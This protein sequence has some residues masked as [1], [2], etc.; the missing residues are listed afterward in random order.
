M[1]A[2]SIASSSFIFSP[3]PDAS[4]V[5]LRLPNCSFCKIL[6]S[7]RSVISISALK[8]IPVELE[9]LPSSA[10]SPSEESRLATASISSAFPLTFAVRVNFSGS[11]T[12]KLS[13]ST[14]LLMSPLLETIRIRGKLNCKFSGSVGF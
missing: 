14:N 7:A 8:D 11:F 6:P 1:L 9:K 12:P 5:R 13:S 2:S 10:M 4:K 3:S